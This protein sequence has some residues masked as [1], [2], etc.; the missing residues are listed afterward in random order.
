[1]SLHAWLGRHQPDL[2]GSRWQDGHFVTE[3][4][5]CGAAMEKRPGEDWT[6]S[7]R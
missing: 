1:M 3:C 2:K 7:K 6:I 5:I 4:T